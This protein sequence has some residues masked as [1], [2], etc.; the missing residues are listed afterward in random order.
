MARGQART[1]SRALIERVP[2]LTQIDG[3]LQ[4]AKKGEG[5]VML[6]SGPPGIGKTALLEEAKARAH[7]RGIVTLGARGGELETHF[8]YGVVRQ[9]FE[10]MLRAATPAAR[11]KL[12]S[13]AAPLAA[14]ALED[15]QV[16]PA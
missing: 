4:D 14:S 15:G 10:P 2:E 7:R 6:I 5:R 16:Q 8:P 9:L 12:L 11:R 1:R 3:M 13:G